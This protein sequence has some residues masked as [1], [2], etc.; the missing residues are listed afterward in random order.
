MEPVIHCVG[1]LEEIEA[2][3][4][5]A[6]RPAPPWVGAGVRLRNWLSNVLLGGLRKL[7]F[8]EAG[9]LEKL[10]RV[11]VYI[12]DHLGDRLMAVPA[13]ASLREACPRAAIAL[14]TATAPGAV[15]E[16]FGDH[17][18]V[19][20]IV[21]VDGPLATRG[22]M[23][24]RYHPG[25]DC[26]KGCDLFVN[27]HPSWENGLPRGV[28]KKLLIARHI[29][30]RSAVGFKVEG[31]A[32]PKRRHRVRGLFVSNDPQRP[33]GVLAELGL[34]PVDPEDAFP[35][36]PEARARVEAKLKDI[37]ATG[38][39]V[40]LNPGAWLQ[41]RRWPAARFAEV[42]RVLERHLGAR[43][44]AHGTRDELQLCRSSL[45]GT[46]G[47]NLAGEVSLQELAGLL[48]MASLCITNDTGPMHYA[49][50]IGCPTLALMS[51]SITPHM[52]FPLGKNVRVLLAYLKDYYDGR[53]QGPPH[54]SL[55]AIQVEDVVRAA[56]AMLGSAQGAECEKTKGTHG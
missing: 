38:P 6:V 22:R 31:G 48:R 18:L 34:R 33:A 1:T 14:L 25:L 21:C 12:P 50:L 29:R 53:W 35:L 8:R 46:L 40:V 49:S 44:V 28:L 5:R 2:L 26:L 15:Q 36:W 52:C 45:I 19:D 56:E 47:L 27:L 43:V 41:E 37:A 51:T 24:L 54:E 9:P 10:S 17:S 7:W 23:G 16:L 42:A 20:Q 11:V 4:E 55:L 32:G 3:E 30:A 39:L 13:L